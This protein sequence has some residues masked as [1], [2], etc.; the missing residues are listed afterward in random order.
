VKVDVEG[1]ELACSGWDETLQR[2][3]PYVLFECGLAGGYFGSKPEEIFDALA[4]AGS[5]SRRWPH[6]SP[7]VIL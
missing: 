2:N 6:G 4:G 7:V 1:A 5:G 3:R